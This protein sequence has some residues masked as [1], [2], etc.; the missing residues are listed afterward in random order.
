MD[1]MGKP[2][3]MIK[4]I[5]GISRYYLTR[6]GNAINRINPALPKYAL[7]KSYAYV[8]TPPLWEPI[9]IHWDGRVCE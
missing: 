2:E 3:S 4:P 6:S 8:L 7:Y 1:I 9:N 5:P